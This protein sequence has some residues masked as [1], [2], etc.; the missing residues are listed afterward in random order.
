MFTDIHSHILHGIDDGPENLGQSVELLKAAV[1]NGTEKIIATPHFYATRHSL[2]ER[3]N[4]AKERC[5]ELQGLIREGGIPV[6]L[7]S[8]F[9][10]RFFD[11]IS[12]IDSLDKLCING[13]KVLL[14]EL[15]PAPFTE[16][17]VDEIL[18]ICYG[19]YTVVLVHIE[20]YTKISGFKQIKRIIAEGDALAQCNASSFL[21]GGFSRAAFKLL[22]ENMVSFIASDMHSLDLRPP[23][24]NQAYDVIEK[25]IGAK[26][27]NRLM[28]NAEELFCA[29]L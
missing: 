11:G 17:L 15:E 2:S 20:R 5:L 9:E 21:S 7:L 14:L 24:L 27:K 22:K 23:N 29:C 26:E 16:K 1:R 25:K 12:R 3:V 8:G 13:S 4:L 28:R 19:G 18:D 6:S 10:V